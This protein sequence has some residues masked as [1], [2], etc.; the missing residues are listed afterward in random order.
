M[1]KVERV[2]SC[3]QQNHMHNFPTYVCKTLLNQQRRVVWSL[4]N[5]MLL[6]SHAGNRTSIDCLIDKRPK[7]VQTISKGRSYLL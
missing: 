7:K 1:L 4:F 3:I 6:L 2:I 5:Q